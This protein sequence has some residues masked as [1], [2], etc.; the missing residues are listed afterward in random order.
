MAKTGETSWRNLA[1]MAAERA[2]FDPE[3]VVGAGDDPAL[4][5]AL[6]TERGILMPRLESALDRFF[7]DSEVEWSEETM[8]LAAE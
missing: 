1:A 2:G 3:R 5:T 7:V 8:R 4:S 6:A